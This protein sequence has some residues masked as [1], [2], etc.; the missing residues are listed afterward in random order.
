MTTLH[1]EKDSLYE[2]LGYAGNDNRDF[3]FW[4][5]A[6]SR[7]QQVSYAFVHYFGQFPVWN[8]DS[9][10]IR[11]KIAMQGMSTDFQCPLDHK[12][13][14]IINNKEVGSI[15]WNGQDNAVFDKRFYASPDSI[16]IYPGNELRI[17]VRGDQCT[18]IDDEIRIN[19][20]EFEYWRGNS[21]FGKYYNFKNYDIYG[22]NAYGIYSWEG[23]D[24]RIYV[25][26]K[27]K[28]MYL[29]MSQQVTSNLLIQ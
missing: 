1:F 23:S 2:R 29:L 10:Y 14:I 28:M 24:M 20:I 6:S 8:T 15:S 19:W 7:N 21:A 25:P 11:L 5:K 13:Y 17:E 27:N 3:W 22:V 4:D 16:P 12:A 26:S 9:A 18:A